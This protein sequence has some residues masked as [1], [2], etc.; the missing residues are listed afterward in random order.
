MTDQ[1]AVLRDRARRERQQKFI[2][3]NFNVILKAPEIAEASIVASYI[4]YEFEP[5][6]AEINEAFLRDGKTLVLPRINGDHLEWVQWDGNPEK[7]ISKKKISEPIGPAIKD[8][9]GVGAIVVPALRIDQSGYRLGQGGGYYDRA[10][11]HL[12]AWKIGLVY[13]GELN[14]EALP[15]EAHDIPLD[16]AASPSIVVRF[17][18]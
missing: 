1:K 4:S 16:A 10:L 18:R 17:N 12:R 15:H 14:S 5:S 9:A 3:C 11:A 2:P 8:L 6:T 7:L 13:A